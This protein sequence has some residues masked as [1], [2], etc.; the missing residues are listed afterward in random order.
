MRR[1]YP[2]SVRE[3]A[4]ELYPAMSI[5]RIGRELGVPHSTVFRWVNP[6]YAETQRLRSRALKNAYRGTCIDC[7][8]STSCGG[9]KNN[10]AVRCQPCERMFR[11]SAEYAATRRKWSKELIVARMQEWATIYGEP[12]TNNDW[13]PYGARRLGDEERA[14][15]YL[16]QPGYWPEHMAVYRHWGSWNAAIEAAGFV[17]NAPNGS[18]ARQHGPKDR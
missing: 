10:A 12:P 7:G 4:L 3:R 15:R 8:G 9:K 5:K 14:Q 17:A 1:P 2:P 6:R 16:A 18:A 13:N 11:R